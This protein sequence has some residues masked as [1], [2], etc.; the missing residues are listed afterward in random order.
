MGKHMTTE[1]IKS[2]NSMS[3]LLERLDDYL[4]DNKHQ[5]AIAIE[6]DWGS[7]KTRF[8]EQ[9]VRPHI[10]DAMKKDMVRVSMFGISNADQLYERIA[11]ALIHM[12]KGQI[13]KTS[14]SRQ[15]N[16]GGTK[17]AAQKI[18]AGTLSTILQ[19]FGVNLNV[20]SS[21]Q[22]IVELLLGDKHFLVLDDIE[23][24][25]DNSDD[26][27]L[28]GAVNALVEGQGIKVCLV[29]NKIFG[30]NESGKRGFDQ[31]I[32]E[33]LVWKVYQFKQ[34]PSELV[35]DIF[36]DLP[37]DIAGINPLNAIRVA[38]E[39]AKCTN[40]RAMIRADEVIRQL[41][42][43]P[44]IRNIKFPE[45]NRKDAFI[46]TIH[47]VLLTCM[48][49]KPTLPEQPE[50]KD[51]MDWT[52][53]NDQQQLFIRYSDFPE[54]E[55]ALETSDIVPPEGLVEGFLRYMNN[56]YPDNDNTLAIKRIAS[57]VKGVAEFE[58]QDVTALIPEYCDAVVPA[59][60]SPGVLREVVMI[61]G[62]IVQLGFDCP[63]SEEDIIAACKKVVER[64]PE[65]ALHNLQ[66]TGFLFGDK[67]TVRRRIADALVEY[68][69]EIHSRWPAISLAQDN[70]NPITADRLV[71]AMSMAEQ[72]GTTS[73]LQF[74]PKLIADTFVNSNAL[75][76]EAIRRIFVSSIY[77]QTLSDALDREQLSEWVASVKRDI[78]STT[79]DSHTGSMRREWFILNLEDRLDDLR[80]KES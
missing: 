14:D 18:V 30:A 36:D 22:T 46:D 43:M 60:F 41:C 65:E 13:A 63:L 16:N 35:N 53:F 48:R 77:W 61:Y 72:F 4:K 3:W 59:D 12:D 47:F 76:Q 29:S 37:D 17:K 67:D 33:K 52:E 70:N 50:S 73:L 15:D 75:G 20:I 42:E 58:D 1:S 10:H 38:A 56:Y 40:A 9:R 26:K 80:D 8:L 31:E 79:I 34:T 25:A 64:D 27:S 44:A 54:I 24:R 7:G 23:R 49:Q 45:S 71:K 2:E 5:Y 62:A 21:M 11:M 68:A 74:A 6:G 69:H 78:E 57:Q 55:H 28:F 19:T 51:V 66:P 32:R 39:R